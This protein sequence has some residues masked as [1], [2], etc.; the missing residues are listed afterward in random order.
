[1]ADSGSP[2]RTWHRFSKW[3]PEGGRGS[4]GATSD[5]TRRTQRS[6]RSE[7][8]DY[9]GG[10]RE[11]SSTRR[12]N[13]CCWGGGGRAAR[14]AIGAGTVDVLVAAQAYPTAMT[15]V[16]PPQQ[17]RPPLGS[18]RAGRYPEPSSRFSYE[19]GSS[20]GPPKSPRTL[21]ELLCAALRKHLLGHRSLSVRRL[22]FRSAL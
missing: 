21:G 13:T 14:F 12:P 1:M 11:P 20:R 4:L 18:A 3:W 9:A 16:R 15:V 17:T 7:Q 2:Q 6:A 8:P 5:E 22:H 10:V 19:F